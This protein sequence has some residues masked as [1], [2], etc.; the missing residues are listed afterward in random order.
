MEVWMHTINVFLHNYRNLTATFFTLLQALLGVFDFE[1]LSNEDKLFGPFLFITFVSVA[2]FVILNVVIA[3]IGL[4]YN[5]TSENLQSME[6]VKLGD[7][8]IDYFTHILQKAPLIGPYAREAQQRRFL[9]Y[10]EQLLT[11]LHVVKGKV[12]GS[13]DQVM[14]KIRVTNRGKGKGYI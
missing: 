2:V 5:A 10:Q 12:D 11:Q 14:K 9:N 8:M 6:D 3:I 1:E 4:S 13:V 7:G